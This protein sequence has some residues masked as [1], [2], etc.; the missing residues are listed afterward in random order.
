M[1]RIKDLYEMGHKSRQEYLADYTA[2]MR[3]LE[4]LPEPAVDGEGLEKLAAFLEDIAL[5][6]EEATQEQRNRLA[7]Q[8]FEVAWIENKELVAVTPRS[9]FKPFFDLQYQGMPEA[10]VHI[11]RRGGAKPLYHKSSPSLIKGRGHRG[12][13]TL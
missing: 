13:V 7:S 11:G 9:E 10:V 12:R 1:E 6:W 4:S 8:I 5:A 3:K 2:I